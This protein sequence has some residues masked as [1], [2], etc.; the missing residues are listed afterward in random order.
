MI[1]GVLESQ[2]KKILFYT[3]KNTYLYI[4]IYLVCV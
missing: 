1:H 2:K 3:D 4:Y